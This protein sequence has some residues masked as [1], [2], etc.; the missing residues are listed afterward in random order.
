VV[1]THGRPKEGVE[2]GYACSIRKKCQP[3]HSFDI[4][5]R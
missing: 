2:G 3:I 4:A 5:E 1:A